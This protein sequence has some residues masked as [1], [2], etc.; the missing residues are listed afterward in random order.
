MTETRL[1]T[2]DGATNAATK[3]TS[4]AGVAHFI[5]QS[6][7]ARKQNLALTSRRAQLR[8]CSHQLF[9]SNLLN[10][11]LSAL[12]L[13]ILAHPDQVLYALK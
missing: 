4:V 9:A 13:H 11:V 8:N 3:L 12:V 1:G 7:D 10:R 6:D 5:G 2:K